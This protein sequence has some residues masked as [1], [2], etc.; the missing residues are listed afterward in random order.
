MKITKV[1]NVRVEVTYN[2]WPR[3]VGCD[4]VEGQKAGCEQIRKDIQRHIDNIGSAVVDW[5]N[6]SYCEHCGDGWSEDQDYFNG[7][8]CDKDMAGVCIVE[9]AINWA[10]GSR[11]KRR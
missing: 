5:D 2:P 11:S 7:G 9:W 10:I 3:I 1:E 6:N 8:C 4:T